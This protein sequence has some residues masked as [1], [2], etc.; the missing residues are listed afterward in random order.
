MAKSIDQ[1]KQKF[2]DKIH[3][4]SVGFNGDLQRINDQISIFNKVNN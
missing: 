1:I 2:D 3:N 4:L